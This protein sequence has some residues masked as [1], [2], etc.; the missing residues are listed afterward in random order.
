MNIFQADGMF[1]NDLFVSLLKN[2]SSFELHTIRA[3]IID[4]MRHVESQLASDLA[5]ASDELAAALRNGEEHLE[6]KRKAFA[7][8]DHDWR[9][10]A[11]NFNRF[12][13]G[14]NALLKARLHELSQRENVKVQVGAVRI[15]GVGL[16]STTVAAALNEVLRR[17]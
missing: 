8:T 5:D 3:Q 4:K 2:G 14:K 1:D 13:I 6:A 16:S 17:G 10:R 7:N 11:A 12:L 9:V 15:V